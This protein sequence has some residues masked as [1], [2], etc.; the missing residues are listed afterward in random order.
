MQRFQIRTSEVRHLEQI[1]GGFLA[2]SFCAPDFRF[3]SLATYDKVAHLVK[4]RWIAQVC[5]ESVLSAMETGRAL[6][7]D[8]RAIEENI[9]SSCKKTLEGPRCRD[10]AT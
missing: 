5:V 1:R 2:F 9:E 3:T 6:K 8:N 4:L 7:D 10:A